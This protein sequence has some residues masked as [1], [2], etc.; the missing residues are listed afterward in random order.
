MNLKNLTPHGRGVRGL[1]LSRSSILFGGAFGRI[2]RALPP[3]EFGPS[4]VETR[5]NLHTLAK[6]MVSTEDKPK[7]GADPEESGIPALFTYL[8]QFVDHDLTFD[9]ASSLQQQNDIDGLTDFRTPRFDLD[10][11][12]GRGPED[13][14]YLYFDLDKVPKLLLGKPLTGGTQAIPPAADLPRN[15]GNLTSTQPAR[16]IIGDPRNDENVIISQLQG[17]FFRFH[18]RFVD[19]HPSL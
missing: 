5:A 10:N 13:Q 1:D 14:P 11:I 9:P 3:A 2:F 12:Y 4:E 18:N 16:A 7:D 19:D 17:L 8:G 6:N 15:G